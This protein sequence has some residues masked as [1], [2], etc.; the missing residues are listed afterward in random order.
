MTLWTIQAIEALNAI[1]TKGVLR[2]NSADA[3][4]SFLPAYQWMSEQMRV[5]VGPPSTDDA[6]PLWA[7]Y[8]WQDSRKRK[9][10]LRFAGHLPK[11]KRGV[12]I[13]FEIDETQALLSDFE[14]WHYVLNYWYLPVSEKEGEKFEAELERHNLSFFQT[15]PLPDPKSHQAIV[16]S[17]QRIFDLNWTV[18]GLAEPKPK[19]AIQATLWEIRSVCIRDVQE[20][21][22]R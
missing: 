19:K 17:W 8:Q 5:R 22:A 11:G 7:W 10:D 9:P 20:F 16:A 13:E 14:L 21:T 2:S 6:L 12:C 4:A 18:K 15:K 3:D 1:K